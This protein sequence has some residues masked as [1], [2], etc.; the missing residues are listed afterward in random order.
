MAWLINVI[1][2]TVVL[3]AGLVNFGL[4][5]LITH[6]HMGNDILIDQLTNR[7]HTNNE[8]TTNVSQYFVK[9]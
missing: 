6:C 7:V 9:L 1:K 5:V 2:S 8:G 4:S 3:G